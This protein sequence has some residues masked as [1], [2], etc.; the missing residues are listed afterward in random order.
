MRKCKLPSCKR[1]FEATYNSIQPCCSVKCAIELG[2]VKTAQKASKE[3]RARKKE[4]TQDRSWHLKNT[5]KAFNKYIRLRDQGNCCISCQKPA[6][7]ENAGHYRSVGAAPE[8]RFE[9]LNCHLQCEHCNSYKSGNIGEYRIHLIK[10][11]GI[12]KVDWIEG[13]HNPRKYTID[14][15]KELTAH[16][17]ALVKEIER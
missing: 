10:K 13:H 14:E 1:P 2:R 12:E 9:E 17:R 15:L 5:Q 3:H 8:L 4:I 16:Y 7:K 11:L 6:K